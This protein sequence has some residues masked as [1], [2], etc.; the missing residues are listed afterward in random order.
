MNSKYIL[1]K[2]NELNYK[3]LLN[4]ILHN[5]VNVYNSYVKN[6]EIFFI[7][8]E[9]DYSTLCKLD[10]KKII[11]FVRYTGLQYFKHIISTNIEKIIVSLVIVVFM[12]LSNNI[13]LD[14]NI[15]TNDKN[16]KSIISYKLMDYNVKEYSLK[17]S[18]KQINKIKEQ[19]LDKYNDQIE[20]LEIVENG[21]KYDVY[22]IEREINK[23]EKDNNKCNYVAKKS[24][25]ITSILA[26]K[27]VLLVQENNYV[28]AGDTL[29]SGE[30]IYNEELKKQVCASG[31]IMGEVWYKV[32]VSYP[33]EVSVKED[34][35]RSHYGISFK[36]FNKKYK[37]TKDK[38]NEVK[39]IINIGNDSFGIIINKS[40]NNKYKKVKYTKEEAIKK[41]LE[42]SR[43]KLIIKLDKNSKILSQNIL[44]KYVNDG[45]MYIEVLLTVEEELGVVENY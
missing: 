1:F 38:Y 24:G 21:Y 16:L 33:L 17:K 2:I 26:R 12:Y 31:L 27:G 23:I 28:T 45:R 42:L 44:K 10:Y 4:K 29:I 25:T 41:A 9:K 30:I 8:N 19:I 13:I 7:V 39:D 20:W 34:N 22:I 32:N 5:N 43:K 40:W 3:Y 14:I 15:H 35:I 37:I 18:C 6:N 11:I 36:L